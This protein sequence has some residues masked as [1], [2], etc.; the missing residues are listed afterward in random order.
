MKKAKPSSVP[1]SKSVK[2]TSAPTQKSKSSV[3]LEKKES[4]RT[5]KSVEGRRPLYEPKS[6]VQLPP[7][8][9]T[10]I[11]RWPVINLPPLKRKPWDP[12]KVRTV[13]VPKPK[14]VVDLPPLKRKTWAPPVAP[15]PRPKPTIEY[16]P[17]KMRS[18][19]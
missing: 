9:N 17:L 1:K 7:R 3:P 6:R 13:P 19:P 18:K 15:K 2:V 14:V 16:P 4:S 12:A 5:I 8:K 11:Q 10:K